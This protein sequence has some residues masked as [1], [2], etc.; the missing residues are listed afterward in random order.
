MLF[1]VIVVL[2]FVTKAPR[3]LP[4]TDAGDT[5]TSRQVASVLRSR[6]PQLKPPAHLEPAALIHRLWAH[7]FL[8][9]AF[10]VQL[11][12]PGPGRVQMQPR[13]HPVG[14]V[15]AARQALSPP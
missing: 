2:R 7:R 5:L 14:A 6:T 15:R 4:R 1:T 12:G 11:Q 8:P 10:E 13:A 9:R 3:A